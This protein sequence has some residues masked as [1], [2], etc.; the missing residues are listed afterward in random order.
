MKFVYIG[1][2][3]VQNCITFG[4]NSQSHLNISNLVE[5]S[6]PRPRIGQLV[7]PPIGIPIG[8]SIAP[9]SALPLSAPPYQLILINIS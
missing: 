1:M 6:S 7:G 5:I 3:I 9:L 8:I 4:I 2:T